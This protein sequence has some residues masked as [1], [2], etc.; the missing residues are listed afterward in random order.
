MTVPVDPGTSLQDDV[1]YVLLAGATGL[2]ARFSPLYSIL[3]GGLTSDNMSMASAFNW[4]GIH[5]FDSAKLKIL[6]SGAAF[7]LIFAVPTVFTADHTLTLDIGDADRSVTLGGNLATAGAVTFAGAFAATLTLTGATGVTLPT[8]GTLATLAG[9]E[10]LS[11]KTLT[12]PQ[13]VDGGFIADSNGNE[14]LVFG[15]TASAVNH[16]KLSNAAT[17][18]KPVLEVVGDDAN[19]S[20]TLQA[21]GTGILELKAAKTGYVDL[22]NTGAGTVTADLSQ[23]NTFRMTATGNFTLAV[24]NMKDGQRATLIIRQDGTGSRTITWPTSFRWLNG[25]GAT[26]STTDKPTLTT[27]PNKV[28]II[29][30]I[31][32]ATLGLWWMSVVGFKGAVS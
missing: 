22:G 24:S 32:D 26:D 10:T 21:K 18:N 27:T 12:A 19:I 3:N 6:S 25:T 8:T 30:G 5:R 7:S 13:F 20:A 28:D 4:G 23:G 16:W 15:V 29:S 1:D 2:H 14:E 11:G 31:Y 17:G 9:T